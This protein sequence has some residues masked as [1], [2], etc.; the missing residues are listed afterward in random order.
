MA[1][2][3]SYPSAT[4]TASDL[5]IGTLVSDT[6]GENPTKSF[7]ISDI[8]GLVPAAGTGGTVT[9]VG[10][11]N[12]NG[13]LTIGNPST[14]TTSGTIDINLTNNGGTPSTTTFYRGDGQWAVPP[15]TVSYQYTLTSVNNAPNIDINLNDIVYG[16]SPTFV[17][18]INGA[19]INMTS[20]N[21]QITVANTGVNSIVGSTFITV[22]SSTATA[23]IVSLANN[24]TTPDNTK[25]Y[26]GDGTWQTIAAG[27]TMSSWTLLGDTGTENIVEAESVKIKG[28]GVGVSVAVADNGGVAEA[29]ISLAN[30]APVT[31]AAAN[32]SQVYDAANI[33]KN[34]SITGTTNTQIALLN[35]L[36]NS[37]DSYT[38]AKVN[39]IVSLTTGEYAA[40]VSAGTT[41][42]NTLYIVI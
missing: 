1:V 20:T 24:S 34:I 10:L 12:T 7:T 15:N 16:G 27:G 39:N 4:P 22:N 14:I 35:V 17:K 37:T 36:S 8:I 21:N 3:Y 33:D 9:S 25:F 41:N 6:S 29:T 30:T 28:D 42:A 32:T 38:S 19:G 11:T 5:L 18:L 31:I 40:L 2:I 13:F 23:P 26:R